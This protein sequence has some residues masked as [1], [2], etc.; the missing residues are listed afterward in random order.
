M[1]CY[2]PSKNDVYLWTWRTT[3]LNILVYLSAWVFKKLLGHISYVQI[4]FSERGV[5][6]DTFE[7]FRLLFYWFRLL[8]KFLKWVNAK[9]WSQCCVLSIACVIYLHVQFY[10]IGKHWLSRLF[11]P[12]PGWI[13]KKYNAKEVLS[14]VAGMFKNDLNDTGTVT[15]IF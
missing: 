13:M 2:T 14:V 6:K 11:I 1:G 10:L 15:N 5:F 9:R 7:W 12:R 3:R 4:L 8:N